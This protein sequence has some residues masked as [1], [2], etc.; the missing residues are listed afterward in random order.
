M[1]AAAP[2][3]TA[4]APVS[5]LPVMVTAVEPLVGPATGLRPLIVGPV[6]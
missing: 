4:L 2:K 6:S 1:A 5:P 3:L